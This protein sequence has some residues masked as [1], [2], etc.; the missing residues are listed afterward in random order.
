MRL[1]SRQTCKISMDYNA[2]DRLREEAKKLAEQAA[3]DGKV[4]RINQRKLN[5]ITN[6]AANGTSRVG[7]LYYIQGSCLIIYPG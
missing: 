5:H 1:L 3:Q 6:P 4:I 7:A 2:A